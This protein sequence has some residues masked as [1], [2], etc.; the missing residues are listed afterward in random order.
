M[1]TTGIGVQ[2][3]KPLKRAMTQIV[4]SRAGYMSELK[5]HGKDMVDTMETQ[6]FIKTGKVMGAKTF[7]TTSTADMYYRDMYG[8]FD[9]GYQRIKGMAKRIF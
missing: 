8:I 6:G 5:P 9:W 7:D 4:Q 1:K 3:W 2:E